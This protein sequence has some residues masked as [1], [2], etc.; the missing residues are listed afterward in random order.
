M[1]QLHTQLNHHLFLVVSLVL[2]I[3]PLTHGAFCSLGDL[4]DVLGLDNG[5]QVLLQDASKVVLQLRATEVREDLTPGWCVLLEGQAKG[6]MRTETYIVLANTVLSD[7]SKHLTC[8]GCGEAMKLER[9]GAIAMSGLLLQ[10]LGQVNDVDR[11]KGAFLE[12][13]EAQEKSG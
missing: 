9:I 5:L 10:V 1:L 11:F 12:N 13:N 7:E 8:T 6:L 4:I 2:L 3:Q